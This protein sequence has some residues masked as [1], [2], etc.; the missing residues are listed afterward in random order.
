MRQRTPKSDSFTTSVHYALLALVFCALNAVELVHA[1]FALLTL[2]ELHAYWLGREG[3]FPFSI[4]PWS[5]Q[6]FGGGTLAMR[7]PLLAVF[8]VMLAV[9]LVGLDRMLLRKL[10]PV[11]LTTVVVISLFVLGV[12][13]LFAL[14]DLRHERRALFALCDRV[15]RATAPGEEVVADENLLLP[16]YTYAPA[17]LRP[18]MRRELVSSN[19][20][21]PYIPATSAAMQSAE[22]VFLGSADEPFAQ[23]L[24][25]AGYS[26]REYQPA[27]QEDSE[28]VAHYYRAAGAGI[29]FVSPPAKVTATAVSSKP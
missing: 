13:Q 12:E 22:I 3:H 28:F 11:A 10:S 8:A 5:E 27:R 29:Y 18:Q 9:A 20:A 1:K 19:E 25:G 17:N 15:E 16:L 2:S 26:F 6:H 7:L 14:R 21:A 23:K 4:L 24:R